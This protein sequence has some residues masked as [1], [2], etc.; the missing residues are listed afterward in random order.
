MNLCYFIKNCEKANNQP[1]IVL[2]LGNRETVA[3][4]GSGG[5]GLIR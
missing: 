3:G 2:F 4:D 5:G 1:H